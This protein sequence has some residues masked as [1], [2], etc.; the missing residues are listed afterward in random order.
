M[1]HLLF[2]LLLPTVLFAG[3]ELTKKQNNFL[4]MMNVGKSQDSKG[5]KATHT[6]QL[7]GSTKVYH[8]RSVKTAMGLFVYDVMIGTTVKRKA[9]E[10]GD[11]KSLKIILSDNNDEQ[12]LRKATAD[13]PRKIRLQK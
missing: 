4:K 1:K 5:Y 9:C 6:L 13:G 7:N 8:V 3:A 11:I 10:R 2:I 12:R